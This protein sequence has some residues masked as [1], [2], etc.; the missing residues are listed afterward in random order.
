MLNSDNVNRKDYNISAWI[1]SKY[2]CM[3]SSNY[4]FGISCTR[5]VWRDGEEEREYDPIL[6]CFTH[7]ENGYVKMIINKVNCLTPYT[8]CAPQ[9]TPRRSKSYFCHINVPCFFCFIF[10]PNSNDV[11]LFFSSK[12]S[13]IAVLL[14][15]FNLHSENGDIFF[16]SIC[17]C[18]V[19]TCTTFLWVWIIISHTIVILGT[20]FWLIFTIALVFKM[21]T[22][23]TLNSMH[24]GAKK[25]DYKKWAE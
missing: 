25:I 12:K 11:L 14:L 15:R 8:R 4:E 3:C 22:L 6:Q 2:A 9:F 19:Q 23:N 24:R 20:L 16:L 18:F 21:K 5:I 10:F 13:I 1:D 7:N 17:G